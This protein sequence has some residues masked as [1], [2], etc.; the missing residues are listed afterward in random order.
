MDRNDSVD[1]VDGEGVEEA[2]R[3]EVRRLGQRVAE[4]E[5]ERR[6][7]QELCSAQIELR[8]VMMEIQKAEG[9]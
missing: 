4:L 7:L 5:E 1:G 6:Q 8:A 9:E 2:L 3:R